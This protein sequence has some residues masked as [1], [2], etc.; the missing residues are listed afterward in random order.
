MCIR[1]RKRQ[2]QGAGSHPRLL[3]D[4]ALLNDAELIG[5]LRELINASEEISWANLE[6]RPPLLPEYFASYEQRRRAATMAGRELH[7]RGGR[8]RLRQALA[9]ALDNYTSI[10]NWWREEG[11]IE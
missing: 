2:V 3:S 10:A 8:A 5:V 6:S 7:R 9:T 1:D 11:W 4:L